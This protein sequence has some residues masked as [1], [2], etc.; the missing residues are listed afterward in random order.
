MDCSPIT[1]VE[2]NRTLKRMRSSSAPSH[3]DRVGYVVFKRC[4]SLVPVPVHLFILCWTQSIIPHEWKVVAIRLIA[5]ASANHDASN[6]AHFQPIALTPCIGKLFTT[7]LRNRWLSFIL[8]NRYLDPS[9]QK[10]FM[11]TVSGCTEHQFKLSSILH[12]A[13]CKHKTLAVCWLDLANAY[14]SVHKMTQAVKNVI[15]KKSMKSHNRVINNP[16]FPLVGCKGRKTISNLMWDT[17]NI[18]GNHK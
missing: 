15:W 1:A 11:P 4:P 14:G 13:Q 7:L 17:S 8:A 5:K 18:R 16:I 6:P 12:E 2:V 3:F 9:L 10:A